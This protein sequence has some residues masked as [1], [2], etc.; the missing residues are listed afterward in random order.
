[1]KRLELE[2]YVRS[3]YRESVAET[4]PPGRRVRSG[5]PAAGDRLA[6]PELVYDQPAG[7]EGPDE[8]VLRPGGPGPL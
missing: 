1:M 7:P 5:G 2:D 4:P 8:H 6:E 3:R